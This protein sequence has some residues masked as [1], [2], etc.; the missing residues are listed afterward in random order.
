MLWNLFD[1]ETPLSIR[2][3]KAKIELKENAK[4][5]F[6]WEYEMLYSLKPK[7]EIELLKMVKLE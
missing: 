5:I 7:R 1:Q 4:P 6:H 3:F 2:Q